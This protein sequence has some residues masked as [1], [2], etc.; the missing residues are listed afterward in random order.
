MHTTIRAL[1]GLAGVSGLVAGI[2]LAAGQR[3]SV[4]LT[5]GITDAAGNRLAAA[6]WSFTTGSR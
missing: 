4:T 1:A 5:D 3:Y 2:T 6:T